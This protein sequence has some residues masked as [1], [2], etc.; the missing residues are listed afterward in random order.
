MSKILFNNG[1]YP[2]FDAG[3]PIANGFIYIGEVDTDP[4]V[5]SNQ[6]QVTAL[7][8]DGSEV[9]IPQPIRTSVGGVPIYNGSP[10]SIFVNGSYSTKV[11]NSDS[12]QIYYTPRNL[13]SSTELLVVG[14]YSD[15]RNNSGIND[16]VIY[17]KGR[18]S[19]GDDGGG[20][21]IF[22][23]S[24]LSTEVTND[25]R[26]GIYVAPNID[27]SG[28]SGAWIRQCDD[29]I[30]VKW[31][32]AIGDGVNDDIL[33]IQASIDFFTTEGGSVFFPKGEYRTTATIDIDSSDGIT[34]HGEG[35]LSINFSAIPGAP[36][37]VGT[38]I[39]TGTTKI[40]A[41]FNSG[42]VI[43]VYK[44]ACNIRDMAIDASTARKSSGSS[45][46]YGIHV[47][48]LDVIGEA[49]KR[50]F[51]QRVRV[52]NQP[53]HGIVFVNDIVAS[54]VDFVD[55]D[56]VEGHGI[57]IAPG[58]FTSRTNRVQP[59]QIQINN[60]RVA[61][62]GGHS[63]L[64]GGSSEIDGLDVPY[65]VEIDNFECFYNCII[66]SI[67][68]DYVSA[69][70]DVSNGYISGTNHNVSTCAFD[71]RTEFP[72]ISDTHT[73]LML[74][75]VGNLV[76]TTRFIAGNPYA[77]RLAADTAA[78]TS[79]R[80]N[81]I[82]NPFIINPFRDSTFYDP[83]I[84]WGSDVLGTIVEALGYNA[85]LTT[86]SSK[87]QGTDFVES[88]G[89]DVTSGAINIRNNGIRS[90]ES[91]VS[92]LDDQAGYIDFN[93]VSYGI[94]LL[95][96]NSNLLGTLLIGFRCGSFSYVDI[97]LNSAGITVTPGV[98][99]LNGTTGPNGSFNIY[100]SD[101]F[102]RLYF[103][104]RLGGTRSFNYTFLGLDGMFGYSA[105][106]FTIV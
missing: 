28:L 90:S 9:N 69:S 14:T 92:L 63:I 54:R 87:T 7:Q 60:C 26:S 6:K 77:I 74:K 30:N 89:R 21:F 24:N 35:G 68:E 97:A 80:N 40:L 103:E 38:G 43:R 94:V 33:A 62:T 19:P 22:N 98:G 12:S 102:P 96:T 5:V 104:N 82:V 11:L 34:I 23:N 81:K 29:I 55:V 71:G 93:N 59:G 49:T 78:T 50:T 58:S 42:P 15:L 51:L 57:F 10:I 48:S 79:A 17:V 106:S 27:L 88:Y 85:V 100:A 2:L 47:E 105:G 16:Q 20:T 73:T 75:G 3:K 31:F 56:H 13:I 32:G 25:T 64:V 95:S 86:L 84:F 46:G 53:N 1:Y 101:T 41:D 37:V 44:R 83:A 99:E 18:I 72:T 4:E 91:L 76:T 66:P 52:L 67:C 8:E 39:S 45:D 61:R 36:G 65:R 70:T